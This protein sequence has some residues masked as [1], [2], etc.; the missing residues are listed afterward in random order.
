MN[1]A[2]SVGDESAL[3]Q[4]VPTTPDPEG[5]GPG[6]PLRSVETM[7]TWLSAVLECAFLH[8]E[9]YCL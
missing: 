8:N 1:S 9:K 7:N 4:E 6:V 2:G 5:P 3:G